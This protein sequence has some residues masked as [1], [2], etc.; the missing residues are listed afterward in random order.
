MTQSG[1]GVS[2]LVTVW[3][4]AAVGMYYHRKIDVASAALFVTLVVITAVFAATK[5]VCRSIGA[6]HQRTRAELRFAVDEA[7]HRPALL[8]L[9]QRIVRTTTY[10]PDHDFDPQRAAVERDL[11]CEDTGNLRGLF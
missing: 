1:A 4:G 7:V 11:T 8:P 5:V 10:V 2:L 3:L 9:G 6:S